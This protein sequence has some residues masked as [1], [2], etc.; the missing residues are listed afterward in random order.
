MNLL[1]SAITRLTS[2]LGEPTAVVT[3]RNL[4]EPMERPVRPG[5]DFAVVAPPVMNF[6]QGRRR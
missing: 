2:A 1:A 4:R 5:D 3:V 6:A